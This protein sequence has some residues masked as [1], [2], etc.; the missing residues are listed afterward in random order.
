MQCTPPT[1]KPVN[2]GIKIAAFVVINPGDPTG[3]LLS[4]QIQ[5]KIIEFCSEKQIPLLADEVY[6]ENVYSLPFVAFKRA[7]SEFVQPTGREIQL[8]SFHS[9]SKGFLGECGRREG[10]LECLVSLPIPSTSTNQ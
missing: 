8:Y 6:Q 1:Q 3:N 7:A 10:Y 4:P 5:R 2:I 9:V